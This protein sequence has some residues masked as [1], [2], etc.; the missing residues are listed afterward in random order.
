M[1]CFVYYTA[2]AGDGGR[3]NIKLTWCCGE[4]E[5]EESHH[6]SAKKIQVI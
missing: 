4:T 1:L 5:E 6:S 2:L 3:D